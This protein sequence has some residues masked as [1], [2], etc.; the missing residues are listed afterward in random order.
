MA[1]TDKVRFFLSTVDTQDQPLP[2]KEQKIKDTSRNERAAKIKAIE[3]YLGVRPDGNL[4]PLTVLQNL[5]FKNPLS[6]LCF[7]IR[8]VRQGCR[9]IVDVIES[10]HPWEQDVKN[11]RLIRHFI[12]EC[13]SPFKRRTLEVTNAKNDE[14]PSGRS[15]W[16]LYIG[17][18]IFIS[19]TLIFFLYWI[20]A[21]GIYQGEETLTA[22][23]AIYGTSAANDILLVQI[24]KIFI[25]YYLPS[26]AMQPQLK[27]IRKVLSDISMKYINQNNESDADEEKTISRPNRPGRNE[28]DL[29]NEIC[30]VQHMSAACRAAW[31]DELKNWLLRQVKI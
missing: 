8:K 16:P 1:I 26:Q 20:F 4:V 2:W 7:K 12:I 18:R 11:T 25:L 29:G 24:T 3:E 30:V 5:Y 23:G 14:Y 28:N 19:G 21:W 27:R 13:L 31:S 22:W 17:S 6:K 10:F 9:E 15:S